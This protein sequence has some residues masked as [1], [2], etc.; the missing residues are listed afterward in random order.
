MRRPYGTPWAAA[1]PRRDPERARPYDAGVE[2]LRVTGGSPLV[3]EVT[4]TG[5][6]NSV[7]KLMAAALLAPG[8]ST[9]TNVPDI[10]DVEIMAELLRRLGCEVVHDLASSTVRIT[11]PR[12]A[13]PPGRLRP[14]PPDA[15]LDLR[16]RPAGGP[17]AGRRR[18]APG[19][20]QHRV[21]RARHA[22]RRAAAHGRSRHERA[23]LPAGPGAR[24][25]RGCARLAGL[26]ERRC[27]RDR[28]HGRR[29]GARGER[30]RQRGAG[31][32]DRRHLPHAPGDGR[33]HRRCRHV[34][35]DDRG[36]RGAAA[37]SST[38]RCRTGSWRA[39]GPSRR[40]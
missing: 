15:C 31:A 23:R 19:R 35:A 33:P 7:L 10:L 16:A 29:P 6:K 32:G 26:P 8:T 4:L 28:S 27:H 5:A 36:C 25:P 24:R 13:G 14:R 39:P 30:H 2:V 1:L 18:R 38:P 11:V 37:R 21:P 12:R 22:R 20:R 40:P 9:I 34:D 17:G 3:G